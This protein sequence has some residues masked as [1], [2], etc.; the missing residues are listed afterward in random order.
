MV[1][2]RA[3]IRNCWRVSPTAASSSNPM[4]KGGAQDHFFA[5]YDYRGAYALAGKKC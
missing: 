2:L 3:K 1:A 4:A 5:K